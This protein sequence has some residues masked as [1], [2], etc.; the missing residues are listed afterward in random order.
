MANKNEIV[1][2]N[3]A[4]FEQILESAQVRSLCAASAQKA[5]SIARSTAPV[6][7]GDY[8]KGLGIRTVKHPTRTTWIV[9]G[10]D[11]KTLL[12]ESKTSNLRKALK[13]TKI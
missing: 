1:K 8:K 11:W 6:Q 13:A 7:T 12:V 5:L 9:Q 10:V 3:D 2:F 4:V